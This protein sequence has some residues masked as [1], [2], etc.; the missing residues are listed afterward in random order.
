MKKVSEGMKKLF[1]LTTIGL[2]FLLTSCIDRNISWKEIGVELTP[3]FANGDQ[4]DSVTQDMIL[5][6]TSI[7]A[8]TAKIFWR[9]SHPDVVTNEGKVNQP[10]VDT[11]VLLSV[12][13]IYK[14]EERIFEYKLM[15][16]A[17]DIRITFDSRGGTLIEPIT[18]ISSSSTIDTFEIPEKDGYDFVGWVFVNEYGH[19]QLLLE[20]IT[21]INY[22]IQAHAVWVKK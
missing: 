5:K 7:I 14:T 16:M 21:I 3:V 9:T 2:V 6:R 19:D 17:E 10:L 18:H 20:G 8:P 1:L 4:I 11:E 13:V 12:R 22:S 15:V